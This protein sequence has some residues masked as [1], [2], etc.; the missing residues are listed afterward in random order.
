MNSLLVPAGAVR[1]DTPAA[2]TDTDGAYTELQTDALGNLRVVG[3]AAVGGNV[4]R[5]TITVSATPD[6]AAGDV[7]GGIITLA[8]VMAAT[9]RQALLR[10]VALKDATGA[11]PALSLLFFRATPAGGTYTD[12][13]AIVFGAADDDNLVGVVRVVAADW[14]TPSGG[15]KS[16]VSLGGIDVVMGS[17]TSDLY[18]LIVADGAYNAAATTDLT[19][20]IGFEQR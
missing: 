19:A 2:L 18:L 7:V 1:K 3:S 8:S 10:S 15:G 16:F 13:A 17:V 5:P 4:Q 12:N 11:G 14:Y 6:Y 9:G 20:E